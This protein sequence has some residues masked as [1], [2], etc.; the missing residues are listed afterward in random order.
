M[1]DTDRWKNGYEAAAEAQA[2]IARL[3]EDAA[4]LNWLERD[5]S[6]IDTE[7]KCHHALFRR[8][9]P[10]TRA[11][12][13]VARKEKTSSKFSEF[14]RNAA[15]NA[16]PVVSS[17]DSDKAE[18]QLAERDAE[19]ARLR[20]DAERYR[21]LRSQ[22]KISDSRFYDLPKKISSL[23]F[24]PGTGRD[25]NSKFDACIDNTRKAKT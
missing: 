13:D 6:Y 3:R 20:E 19:I 5:E 8:N 12:I 25:Y 21:W 10:I 9:L 14:I 18:A 22:T 7:G 11:A 1:S 23:N 24:S 15:Q 2:E 16:A 4:R 17:Q